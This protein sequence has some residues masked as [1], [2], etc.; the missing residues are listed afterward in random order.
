MLGVKNPKIKR[1]QRTTSEMPFKRI[2]K[3]KCTICSRH[4]F[5]GNHWPS[6]PTRHLILAFRFYLNNRFS[7]KFEPDPSNGSNGF[8]VSCGPIGSEWILMDSVVNVPS[9]SDLER[10]GYS[11][12][13]Y[14]N[15]HSHTQ[16]H[17]SK[18]PAQPVSSH[19]PG[20]PESQ[21]FIQIW[22]LKPNLDLILIKMTIRPNFGF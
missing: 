19:G 14:P 16:S 1:R 5:Q 9:S 10:V 21:P 15:H 22:N 4:R 2:S 13:H 20:Q 8:G 12:N 3:P 7:Q 18:P 11:S 17:A 6:D